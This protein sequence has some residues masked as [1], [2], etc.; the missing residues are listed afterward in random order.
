MMKVKE[1]KEHNKIKVVEE[2][3]KVIFTIKCNNL[4]LNGYFTLCMNC[5]ISPNSSVYQAIMG[6]EERF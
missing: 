6:K 1:Y 3:D 5:S 4:L 2:T